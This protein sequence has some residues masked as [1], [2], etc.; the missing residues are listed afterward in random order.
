[1]RKSAVLRVVPEAPA[2]VSPLLKWAGGKRWFVRQF[3]D[4]M[5]ER[6]LSRG[7]RYVEPYLGG[8]AMALHL[9]I[10]NMV[11]GDIEPEL[12][13]TYRV[14][15]DF[16]EDLATYL[17][18]LSTDADSYYKTREREPRT[19]VEVAAKLIYLN[20][21]CFNGLYRK[22]K[23]GQ[24]N[25]PYGGEERKLPGMEQILAVSTALAGAKV[26]CGDALE[27]IE[28][29]GDNDIIYA[30][31]PYHGT[32]SDYT[33]LGFDDADQT[34]LAQELRNAHRRGAEVYAH[35]A[36]TELVRRLYGWAEIIPLG[37]R[38]SINSKRGERGKVPCV[39]VVGAQ[40]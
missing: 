32:F 7:G 12:V 27:L 10:K 9:G 11:L 8:A 31:P 4:D 6:V 30:D 25:V 17:S 34:A 39:L 28:D 36:D 15:Q 26:H 3:G 14:V 35:N 40:D 23:K 22:N 38:R 33:A 29:A 20:K 1:M 37:E 19:P 18:L 16:P 13:I 5:F 24:F 21:L 2:G